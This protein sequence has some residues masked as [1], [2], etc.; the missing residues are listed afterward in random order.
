MGT[1]RAS[2]KLPASSSAKAPIITAIL[3]VSAFTLGIGTLVARGRLAWPPTQLLG[4]LFTVA[5]C[6]ALVGPLV[7]LT[8]KG[9]GP[10]GIGELLWM[11]GGL[12]IWVFDAAAIVRGEWRTLAPATPLGVR[13]MG[14]TILAVLL[15]GWRWRSSHRDWSWT[16]VTGWTL[17][18]FWVG[19]G[20]ASIAPAGTLMQSA[21]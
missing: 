9:A 11:A 15:S 7:L 2:A 5:G 6:L 3:L 14:L 21:R 13:A 1:N 20:L 17:G 8:R 12:I 16:N 18:L 4:S 10:G 19:L